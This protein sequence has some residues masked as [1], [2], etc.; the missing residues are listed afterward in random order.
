MVNNHLVNLFKEIFSRVMLR[1][2]LGN[3]RKRRIKFGVRS[4]RMLRMRRRTI[5]VVMMIIFEIS[6][7]KINYYCLI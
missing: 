3:L 6:N 1:R 4:C 7:L 5:V 2:T